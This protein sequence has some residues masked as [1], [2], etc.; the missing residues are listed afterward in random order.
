MNIKS[1]FVDA[2]YPIVSEHLSQEEIAR[3]IEIPNNPDHGDLAFPTFSLAKVF[4][5]APQAIAQEIVD[6][7]PTEAFTKV[8]ALGPYINLSLKRQ[9]IGAEL[10]ELISEEKDNYGKV[11]IGGGASMTIDFSSPNI[12]KPMSMGHLRS[13][14]IG[15]AIAKI[16]EK[17]N[18]KAIRINH[19][20]DWGTQFGKLIVAYKAWGDPEKVKNDPINELVKLYVEFHERAEEDPELDGQA[21]A[22]FKKL[23]DGDQE[24]YEL[25]EQFR[26]ESLKE[27]QYVYDMLDI[28][29]DAFSGEAFYNDKMQGVID[30]L[31]E[32]GLTKLDQGASIV[33]L[34]EWDLPPALIK[35]SD[36]ASL[37]ITRDLAAATY[38]KNTYD[39][40]K[41]VYVVGNEQSVH[42]RQLKAV[43][44]KMGKDWAEDIVHVPFGLITLDGKKLSTRK[45]KIVLL[46]EVL[47]EAVEIA[48]QQIEA[49]NPNLENKEEIAHEVGVGAVVFHDLK[50]DRMNN[51]DFK[52]EEIVQFEG[53]TGPYVQYTYARSMSLMRRYGKE[54]TSDIDF[55]L[56]DDYSW[57]IIKKL[58]D[59]PRIISYAIDRFEPSFIAKY[60]LQLAQLFNKYYA[61]VR[62]LNEDDQIESRMALIKVM[63]IVIKDALSLLGVKAPEEM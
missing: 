8:E 60:I 22:A 23:E 5:K 56:T 3:L 49:K 26:N 44:T 42:F 25:W 37:Y 62:I 24:M 50:T 47:K 15:N 31:E 57:E 54:I 10:I 34:E 11:D 32:S 33:D 63:T 41:N 51:F 58:A 27:F 4:R 39:F 45:G 16:A 29:F 40:A 48:L 7:L 43:L 17:A 12:A 21:R 13:T 18:Y 9:P 28:D 19:L 20:G 30:E 35:K 2:L 53:E 38:R 14:V 36:G 6:Q 59:Y 61:N 55:N 1:I 52:L 46:E